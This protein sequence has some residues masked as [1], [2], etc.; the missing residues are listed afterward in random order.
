APR[1]AA[2]A[3]LR[4]RVGLRLRPGLQRAARLRRLPAPQAA[5][6]GGAPA[7]A[8]GARR[9]LRA[10]RAMTLRTRIAAAAGLA[11]AVAVI[12]AAAIVYFAI[13]SELRGEVERA[14]SD[15][16]ALLVGFD[17]GPR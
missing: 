12:A 1:A 5:G 15:R 2:R 6:R 17:N 14:L 8:H 3:H 11:V 4:P 16:A 10:A 9:R 13:R 7:R